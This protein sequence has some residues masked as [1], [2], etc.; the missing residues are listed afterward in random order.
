MSLQVVVDFQVIAESP[1]WIVVNKPAP[2]IVHP[3]NR[4]PEPTLLG[5]IEILF[6]YEM[7]N[8][9][10]P[11]IVTRLDRD[12]SGIVLVAMHTAAARELGMVFERR[13]ARKEYLA[14]VHGWPEMDEW[15]CRVPILRAGEI[16]TSTIWVRQIA[17]E[18]GKP[19]ST[20]FL[21]ERRFE[22]VEGR[23][24]LV[25]CFPE[26]G[27]MHQLRVHLAHGGHPIVGDKLYSGDGAEYIEWMRT[28]WTEDLKS[29]L[30]LPRHALHAAVLEVPWAGGKVEWRSDLPPDLANF[31]AGAEVA[32]TPGV[33]IWS[34]HD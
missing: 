26:T 24:S 11:A 9:A 8:G 6:S 2:L 13:E 10:C 25:R 29:R 7:E 5:G 20:R 21:V 19:C 30:H 22:R 33:V 17:H 34:R 14:L 28:G 3:A 18:G 32:D 27:R 16:G 1:D 12:T 23:F 31:M 15:E 4:K